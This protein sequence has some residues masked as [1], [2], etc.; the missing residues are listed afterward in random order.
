MNKFFEPVI[1]VVEF[2][3]MDVATAGISEVNG[4]IDQVGGGNDDY[5]QD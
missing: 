1:G 4:G 3:A 5:Y 2:K